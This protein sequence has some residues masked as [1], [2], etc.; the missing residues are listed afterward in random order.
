MPELIDRV[1]S[2]KVGTF[3]MIIMTIMTSSATFAYAAGQYRQEFEGL[4]S[5]IAKTNVELARI[6]TDLQHQAST[7]A[8]NEGRLDSIQALLTQQA[9]TH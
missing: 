7:A 9:K 5:E 1:I 2:F 4:R 3:G 8:R 6:A